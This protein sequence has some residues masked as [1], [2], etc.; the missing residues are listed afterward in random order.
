M[1]DE[2]CGEEVSGTE[3]AGGDERFGAVDGRKG[4]LGFL[5]AG[6]QVFEVYV[7]EGAVGRKTDG[8]RKS[9]VRPEE[10]NSEA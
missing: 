9:I 10:V 8:L 7:W 1:R 2:E 4:V 3:E 5:C 6:C